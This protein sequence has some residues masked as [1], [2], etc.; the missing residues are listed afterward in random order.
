[1]NITVLDGAL[2]AAAAWLATGLGGLCAPRHL[3]WLRS[4]LY[5]AGAAVGLTLAALGL[6]ALFGAPQERLLPLGLPDLPFHA[7]LDALSA[8]FLLIL[9]AV[10]AG[11]SLFAAGYLRAGETTAP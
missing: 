10:S 2:L 6:H 7:R 3:G 5:P 4:A 11:I 9:G 1:M 8:F